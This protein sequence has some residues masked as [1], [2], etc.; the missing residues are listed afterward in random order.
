MFSLKNENSLENISWFQAGALQ[1]ALEVCNNKK[2]PRG[3][4]NLKV[5]LGMHIGPTGGLTA[6]L[7]CSVLYMESSSIT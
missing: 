2:T 4:S 5:N 7:S 3:S 1:Q 6:I